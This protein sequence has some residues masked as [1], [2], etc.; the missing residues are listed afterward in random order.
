MNTNQETFFETTDDSNLNNNS[1]G[2][3]AKVI[4]VGGAGISLVD[5]LRFDNFDFVDNL[6]IDVDMKAVADSLAS[7]KLTFG[8]RHTRGRGQGEMST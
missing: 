5:G 7:H 1:F 3:R 2:I 8:R 4:G 6:I